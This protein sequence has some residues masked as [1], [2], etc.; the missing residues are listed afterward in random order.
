MRK[1]VLKTA[2]IAFAS[3]VGAM[4]LFCLACLLFFPSFT[5]DFCWDVGMQ[6]ASVN[7]AEKA[8]LK[9]GEDGDL[10]VLVERAI[11]AENDNLVANYGELLIGGEYFENYSKTAQNEHYS[12]NYNGYIV[13]NVAVSFYKNGRKDKALLCVKNHLNEYL[14]FNA[15]RYLMSE[16]FTQNDK[17]FASTLKAFLEELSLDGTQVQL[18]ESDISLLN[19]FIND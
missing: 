11:V 10:V 15:A 6:N 13:G 18:V 14:P 1:L 5:S 19:K 17:E 9:S 12:G 2:F 3:T 8:Y 7:Y 16:V 4:L